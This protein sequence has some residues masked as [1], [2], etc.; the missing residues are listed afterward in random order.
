MRL[1]KST[2][3]SCRFKPTI[4]SDAMGKFCIKLI[5]CFKKIKAVLLIFLI[6]SFFTG[7]KKCMTERRGLNTALGFVSKLP[8]TLKVN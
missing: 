3:M 2:V 4:M 1:V 6:K 7:T 8:L 5:S